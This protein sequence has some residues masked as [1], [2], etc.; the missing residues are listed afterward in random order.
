MVTFCET[1]AAVLM[2]LRSFDT[3]TRNVIKR[4][5][6]NNIRETSHKTKKTGTPIPSVPKQ[7]VLRDI[8]KKQLRTREL[9]RLV[10]D[11]SCERL[12][13]RPR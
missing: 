5:R 3:T 10:G 12:K 11:R 9:R 6:E 4:I 13:L 2:V 7:V 1:L 8:G